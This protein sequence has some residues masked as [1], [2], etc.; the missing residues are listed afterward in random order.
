MGPINVI[1]AS[2]PPFEEYIEEIK[3]LWD[4]RIITN[5]GVKHQ[6]L[7]QELCKYLDCSNVT[8]F[9]NGHLALET[10]LMGL[11]RKGEI[12]TT[13]FTFASTPHAIVRAGHIPV[14]CD[15]DP[16]DYTI[17]VNKIEEL[18]TEKTCAIVPVHVYGHMCDVQKI[19][20]IAD[21]YN[22]KV[23]YDAAHAFGV[24]YCGKSAV[25][26]G[27]VSMI[28]FH[29]TK[30]FNTIEGG[31][32]CYTNEKQF[33]YYYK[34]KNFGITG[35]ET[36]E[37]VGGNAKL[38]EFQAAMGLCNLRYIDQNIEK[39]RLLVERYR[40]NLKSR[41]DIKLPPV[42]E[43]VVSN[44]AYFPILIDNSAFT[45]DQLYLELKNHGV[46][47][48]K[49]FYPLATDFGCYKKQ[50]DSTNTSVAKYVA[51]HVLTLP[52]YADLTLEQV[53]FICSKI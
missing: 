31:A 5:M 2:L 19:Q 24:R 36:V 30:I 48:R 1:Q 18:I 3:S 8:L 46:H 6:R 21:K 34:A 27:D 37:E 7:E 9:S 4:S 12:I 22:L 23:I 45:R 33:S 43:F 10:A 14:F 25:T 17:D 16:I 28:S 53:D 32:L 50:Y 29:A 49:Y 15:I 11:E 35:T 26:F 13:P 42:Q 52:L 47:T 41:S 39:R 44:Y 40:Y 20:V 51:E 38:N